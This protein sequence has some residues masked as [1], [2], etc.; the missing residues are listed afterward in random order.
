MKKLAPL[1]KYRLALLEGEPRFYKLDAVV[2]YLVRHG[3]IEAT[4]QQDTDGQRA[5]YAITHVGR[6]VLRR[7][8][9]NADAT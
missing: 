5:E 8:G 3:L 6:E 1:N 9:P 7:S 4:G 2:K